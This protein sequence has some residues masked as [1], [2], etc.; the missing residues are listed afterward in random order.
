LP[1]GYLVTP[2]IKTE[3]A[4]LKEEIIVFPPAVIMKVKIDRK[5]T[6]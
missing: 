1:N 2:K 3:E 5:K 6:N 4:K